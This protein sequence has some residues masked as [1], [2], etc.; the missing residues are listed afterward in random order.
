MSSLNRIFIPMRIVDA[1]SR[2]SQ[3]SP[4]QSSNPQTDGDL[5]GNNG[6]APIGYSYLQRLSSQRGILIHAASGPLDS[7]SVPAFLGNAEQIWQYG[8]GL[9]ALDMS[10]VPSVDGDGFGALIR[11]QR[12]LSDLGGRLYLIGCCAEVR[13]ARNNVTAARDLAEYYRLVMLPLR[14]QIVQRTRPLPASDSV[15]SRSSGPWKSSRPASDFGVVSDSES[16]AAR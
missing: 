11:M 5:A 15:T 13:R 16:T 3:R 4:F 1:A 7:E 2:K 6:S 9:V 8:G 12:R 14:N 10:G